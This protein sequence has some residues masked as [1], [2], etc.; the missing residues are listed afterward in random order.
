MTAHSA[1]DLRGNLVSL[2]KGG[3]GSIVGALALL[4]LRVESDL[5]ISTLA[6]LCGCSDANMTGHVD[7]LEAAGYVSRVRLPADRRVIHVRLL[8]KGIKLLDRVGA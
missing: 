2:A 1:L 6:K 3:I 7:R 4:S 5:P 8:S